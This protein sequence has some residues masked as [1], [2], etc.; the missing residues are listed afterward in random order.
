MGCK[1]DTAEY[2]MVQGGQ[3]KKRRADLSVNTTNYSYCETLRE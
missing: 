2:G 1:E 3:Q